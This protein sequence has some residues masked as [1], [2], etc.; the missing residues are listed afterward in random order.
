MYKI[1]LSSCSKVLDEKLFAEFAESGIEAMEISQSGLDYKYIDYQALRRCADR[2]HI[3]LWSYHL[4]FTTTDPCTS[5]IGFRNCSVELHCEQIKQASQ[6]GIHKFVLHAG[7]ERRQLEQEERA[8][9][10]ENSKN[11]LNTL[12]EYAARFG[13]QI[14]V[15]VLPRTCLGRN[16]DE[17]LE[18]ISVND[19]LRVCLDTNHLLKEDNADF[20]RKVGDK[21]TTL[22][23]S[24]YDFI[25]ER[26]W[27]PGEGLI[28]WN[29][30]L[31]ALK[32]VGYKG[33]WMYE[34]GFAC[35]KGLQR[36][37]LNCADF[38]RN[39]HELFENKPLTIVGE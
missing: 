14:C 22:H 10:M 34:I 23:V 19:K 11:S 30:V 5:D 32:E 36:R 13:G 39:A 28:Q 6:I 31:D 29:S 27:L 33:V 37:A 38:V 16:S 24:D 12:A 26:H 20:I 9:L 2:Y 35:P 8:V 18:L 25:D 7:L 4:P 3:D 15:E 21:I 17:I 1:G